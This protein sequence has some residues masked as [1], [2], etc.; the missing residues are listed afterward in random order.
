MVIKS[1]VENMNVIEEYTSS[2]KKIYKLKKKFSNIRPSPS[3]VLIEI[4]KTNMENNS[5][6]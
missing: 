5:H 1:M 3:F 4:A 2:N 6:L